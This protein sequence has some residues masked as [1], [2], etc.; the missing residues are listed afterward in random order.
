[1]E[2]IKI[3]LVGNH[4]VWWDGVLLLMHNSKVFEPSS[5][6]YTLEDTMN[7][8]KNVHPDI[9]LLE[10]NIEDGDCGKVTRRILEAHPEL[11]IIVISGPNKDTGLLSSIQ[12]GAKAF[13]D[14]MLTYP[15][16]EGCINYIA[17]GG[18]AVISPMTAKKLLNLIASGINPVIIPEGN[19][20]GLSKREK[21]VLTLLAGKSMTNK[22]IANS[23]NI[24]ENTVKVHL[25]GILKKLPARNRQQA[26]ALARKNHLIHED[27]I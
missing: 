11:K 22:E 20:L 24:T 7:K 23:L 1:M 19:D 5:V 4:E 8:I 25:S 13:I 16:L 14:K 27:D 17:H 15:E 18:E 26:A 6:C 12:A 3:I 21:Q 9:I 2:K 10:E